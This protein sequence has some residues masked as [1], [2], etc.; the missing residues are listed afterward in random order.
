MGH[1]TFQFADTTLSGL[2][3]RGVGLSLSSVAICLTQFS[4]KVTF[5]LLFQ[6]IKYHCRR[7]TIRM[8]QEGQSLMSFTLSGHGVGSCPAKG[9]G[10][11]LSTLISTTGR[12]ASKHHVCKSCMREPLLA[13]H[14]V[15]SWE[16]SCEHGV[17]A[18]A[19]TPLRS[20][21][22]SLLC[23]V[24]GNHPPAC[25]GHNSIDAVLRNRTC[26]LRLELT[27]DTRTCAAKTW[28]K[29]QSCVKSAKSVV[30][31]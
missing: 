21:L 11:H 18:I 16:S 9:C 7:N 20:P 2:L 29:L 5:A 23:M 30:K 24:R 8:E 1:P 13:K 26:P 19:D 6:A 28:W 14:P 31:D 22:H 27:L 12:H 17:Q 4:F 10:V 3:P 15:I 25:K